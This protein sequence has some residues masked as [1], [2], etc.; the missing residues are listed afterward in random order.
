[1]TTLEG[2]LGS[3]RDTLHTMIANYASR[4]NQHY[5]ELISGPFDMFGESLLQP[6]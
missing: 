1:M 6:M 5:R 4:M 3:A 2:G